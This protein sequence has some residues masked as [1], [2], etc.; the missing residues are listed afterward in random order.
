ME[1]S[2][3]IGWIAAG[4]STIISPPQAVKI[5]QARHSTFSGKFEAVSLGTWLLV[6]LNAT[7]WL[8][9]AILTM[10]YPV[11]FLSLV[12]GPLG[13]YVIVAVLRDRRSQRV[14]SHAKH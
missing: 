7:L 2:D 4:I 3:I 12:N 5:Y 11:G 8:V 1:A 14:I 13:L 10:A 9:Y 6:T